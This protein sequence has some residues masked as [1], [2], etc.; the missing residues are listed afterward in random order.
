[1]KTDPISFFKSGGSLTWQIASLLFNSY[2]KINS[3]THTHTHTHTNLH[4]HHP[5]TLPC[6]TKS[7]QTGTTDS[8]CSQAFL[9]GNICHGADAV[10]PLHFS[11][12]PLMQP[13][14]WNWN[15]Q[16]TE[17]VCDNSHYALLKAL[18]LAT[19]RPPQPLL[20]MNVC[21]LL[22]GAGPRLRN[23]FVF[24]LPLLAVD[25]WLT[26]GRWLV[27]VSLSV[28]QSSSPSVWL[29]RADHRSESWLFSVMDWRTIQVDPWPLPLTA[30]IGS[31]CVPPW[32]EWSVGGGRV[33]TGRAGNDS[34]S[35]TLLRSTVWSGGWSDWSLS[36]FRFSQRQIPR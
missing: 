25:C 34:V 30:G 22:S 8:V 3:L 16:Q 36:P 1:M 9:K 27:V 23:D 24:S 29:R 18:L 13:S 31:S 7:E 10:S 12:P 26:A 4:Q 19:V 28:C 5:D 2:R 21:L 32:E 6:Q 20:Y 17:C 33:N 14:H 15:V 35:W 11:P